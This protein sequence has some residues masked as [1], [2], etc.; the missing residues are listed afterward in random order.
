MSDSNASSAVTAFLNDL[1]VDA[2]LSGNIFVRLPT[3]RDL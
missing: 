1:C 2:Y 3:K